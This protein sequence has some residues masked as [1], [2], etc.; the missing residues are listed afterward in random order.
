MVIYDFACSL[1]DYCLNRAPTYFRDT[2]FFVDVFHWVNHVACARSFSIRAYSE[3]KDI[4]MR[5]QNSEACEQINAAMKRLR[6]VLSRMGQRAFMV[7]LRLFLANWNVGKLE[8][9]S[10]LQRHGDTARVGQS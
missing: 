9:V 8:K 4:V 1:M 10:N 2:L 3:Y 5:T 6:F 7:F